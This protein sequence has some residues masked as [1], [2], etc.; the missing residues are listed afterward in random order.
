MNINFF[1]EITFLAKTEIVRNISKL[2]NV[3][4]EYIDNGQVVRYCLRPNETKIMTVDYVLSRV[5]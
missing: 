2:Y 5:D 4:I 3:L 1:A